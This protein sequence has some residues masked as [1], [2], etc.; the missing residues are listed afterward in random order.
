MQYLKIAN[1]T[2]F[3][4]V[5]MV[6]PWLGACMP[7]DAGGPR[8]P[9]GALAM[10]QQ[11]TVLE[12]L[13]P[14]YDVTQPPPGVD[15][16]IWQQLVIPEDNKMTPERVALGKKLY[17]DTRLSKD[18]TVACAT[19]HDVSRGFTDQRPVSEGIGD[20]SASATRRPR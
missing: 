19:C 1:R 3:L 6:L 8:G 13:L 2:A 20:S 17:F 9:H 7:E 5:T 12:D 18:G 14:A 4:I 10:S 16:G 11:Q 15:P